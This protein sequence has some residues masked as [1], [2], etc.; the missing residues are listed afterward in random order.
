M[1]LLAV[2]DLCSPLSSP[3]TPTP[4]P[5]PALSSAGYA[6]FVLLLHETYPRQCVNISIYISGIL[7]V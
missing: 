1:R 2:A 6:G 4:A 3:E 5:A 7:Y